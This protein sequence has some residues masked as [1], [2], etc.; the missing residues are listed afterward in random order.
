[1]IKVKDNSTEKPKQSIRICESLF[2]LYHYLLSLLCCL[3]VA[4]CYPLGMVQLWASIL[5]NILQT[6]LQAR[7]K[8]KHRT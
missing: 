5:T 3:L 1:M 4:D 6:L 8:N 7:C 2:Q